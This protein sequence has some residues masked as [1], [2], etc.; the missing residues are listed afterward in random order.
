VFARL[1]VAATVAVSS[2]FSS[3]D[4]LTIE[5]KAPFNDLFDH[6]RTDETYGVGGT[7][8][9]RDNGRPVTIEGVTITVRGNTSRRESECAF[10]KLKVQL[11]DAS[12][13]GAAPLFDGLRSIKI[14]THCGE[15][16]DE[17]V[18]VKYGRL[19]N[20]HSPARELFV[21]RLLEA[22]GVPTLK[23]RGATIAYVYSDPQPR[24]SPP[25]DRP[26]VRQAM[27]LE[28]EDA[29]VKRF[30]G[31]HE[32]GEKEFTNARA[33]FAAADTV[34]LALAEAM[35]GNFDWCLK[36]VPGDTYRCDAR[37]PLWN[38]AAAAS[39]D[40][41]AR[42]IMYDFDVSGIVTGHHPWFEDV[43]KAP[44]I[45][46]KSPAE[47]EVLA[48]V[49]RTRS[50]F[51]RD[52]LDTARREFIGR[53]AEAYKALDQSA[54]DDAGRTI[55]RQY[56][57]AFYRSIETDDVFY[58]PVVV[59][60]N[61]RL[62]ADEGRQAACAAAGTIPPGTPVSEPLKKSGTLVQVWI[63]DALWHWAPPVKCNAVREGPL[64]IEA[65]SIG[66]DYPSR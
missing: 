51:T 50:L 31:T 13:R 41:K 6:A 54:L 25:E 39:A 33:Q 36:M 37:H 5:L 65:A 2:L 1:V 49:Q 10:P 18:T 22:L 9:Y 3:F 60:P 17:G 28:D 46:T 42:P 34:R 20:E 47:T 56:L 29:A 30:G 32:I 58:R 45:G 53:K 57:D 59:T 27:L 44:F 4:R 35:I 66:R 16:P 63:L 15:A 55:A 14:G 19:P 38:V 64:W 7:L 21:Y 23:A 61:A 52:E 11:P 26:V 43:F 48:Q 24:Q 12:A 40:G 8:T 62:Y